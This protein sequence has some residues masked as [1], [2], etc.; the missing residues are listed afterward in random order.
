L[1]DDKRV[2][3][4][5]GPRLR[6]LP[7]SGKVCKAGIL[8]G[9]RGAFSL[10]DVDTPE[11]SCGLFGPENAANFEMEEHLVASMEEIG[12]ILQRWAAEGR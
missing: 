6:R 5:V 3:E 1:D 8:G 7:Q 10:V 11:E 9:K 12:Q 2:R 4:A